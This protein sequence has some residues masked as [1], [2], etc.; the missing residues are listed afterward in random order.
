MHR[1]PSVREYSPWNEPNLAKHPRNYDPRR[2]A[3]YYRTLRTLCGSC[4]LLGAD[5]VDNSSLGRWMRAYLRQFG[6]GRKPKIWG[7]H[8]YVDVNSTSRW[9]TE[10]MLRVA[11]GQ[12]WFTETGA[13][14]SRRKPQGTGPDDRRRLIRTGAGRAAA[15]MERVFKL[16]AMSPRIGRVYIYHWRGGG[17]SSWDSGLVSPGGTPRPSYD[18]F[19]HEARLAAGTADP[20]PA[21]P[22]PPAPAPAPPAEPPAPP[23]DLGSVLA[24]LLGSHPDCP[25][26]ASP[27]VA[28]LALP[29]SRGG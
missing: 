21:E 4:R 17:R 20:P 8:N 19:A 10:T 24:C 13:I 23:Q 14:I 1:Y 11:P 6:P 12:I 18:V 5:V 9:G 15:A 2:I 3:T 29:A 26:P 22:A 7:L 16:A 28:A 25:P 27:S